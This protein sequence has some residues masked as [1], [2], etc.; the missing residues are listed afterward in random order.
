MKYVLVTDDSSHWYVI[1]ADKQDEWWDWV[2][3]SMKF[4][5]QQLYLENPDIED[6]TLPDWA[7][8]VGGAPSLVEFENYTI[9]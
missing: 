8:E 4:W 9:R 1:P 6:P 7:E 2:E 3:Y 5:D